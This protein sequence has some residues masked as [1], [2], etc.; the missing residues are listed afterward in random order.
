[1]A[2][3][4]QTTPYDRNP[5]RECRL[6]FFVPGGRPN[7]LYLCL[8]QPVGHQGDYREQSEQRRRCPRYR[9]VVPSPL[10]FYSKMR[11]SLFKGHFHSPTADEPTQNLQRRK[12]E[13]GGQQRLRLKFTRR[14]SDQYPADRDRQVSAA[15]PD[16]RVGV[17]FC[18]ALL[19][20]IPMTDLDLRPF[21]FAIVERLLRRRAARA[22]YTWAA[23]LPGLRLGAKEGPLACRPD[24]VS[25]RPS[26]FIPCCDVCS[27]GICRPILE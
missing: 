8:D 10:S 11:P 21:R 26:D 18:F 19:P 23:H 20:A 3:A 22:F 2:T 17:D 5:V 12:P 14:I 16:R 1:M 13:V 25:C 9:Q 4:P 15:I 7:R 6:L 27:K 24:G